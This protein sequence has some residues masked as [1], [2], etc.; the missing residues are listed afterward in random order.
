[1][2]RVTTTGIFER[3]VADKSSVQRNGGGQIV[4][5]NVGAGYVDSDSGK[6]ILAAGTIMAPDTDTGYGY[7]PHA[8]SGTD[9]ATAIL[10]TDA[11]EDAP[12]A[13]KSGYGLIVGGVIYDN[14]LPDAG[15]ADFATW[16]GELN[17]AGVGQFVWATAEDSSAA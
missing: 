9:T 12:S 6:K 15:D 16:K 3:F 7:I 5:A 11:V 1:M 8:D 2:P 10:A 13:A 14:L 17:G 4:W